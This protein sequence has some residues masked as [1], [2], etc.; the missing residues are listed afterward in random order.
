MTLRSIVNSIALI[1]HFNGVCASEMIY[2]SPNFT[3]L[4]ETAA[5][6]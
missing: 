4:L 5:C 1:N 6:R 2:N 3:N